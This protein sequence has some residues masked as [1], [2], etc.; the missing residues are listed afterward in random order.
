MH[1]YVYIEMGFARMRKFIKYLDKLVN[2]FVYILFIIVFLYGTYSVYDNLSVYNDA[3]LTKNIIK[4]IPKDDG[5]NFSLTE[6][7]AINEDICGWLRINKTNIDYPI[8]Q[9]KDNLQYLNKNYEK[10]FSS[11]GSI[12]LDYRNS[13]TFEDDYSILYGHNMH[14]NT[15]FSDLTAYKDQEFL[16]EHT[17]GRLYL[18]DKTYKIEIFAYDIIDAYANTI[19]NVNNY[20]NDKN[21]EIASYIKNNA[22]TK[23]ELQIESTDKIIVFSTCVVSQHSSR[24]I[25]AARLQEETQSEIKEKTIQISETETNTRKKVQ[26]PVLDIFI[27]LILIIIIFIFITK[28]RKYRNRRKHKARHA[29]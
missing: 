7:K 6:L 3:K 13:F 14:H 5:S 11:A 24:A 10:E 19:Y 22:I 25:V 26:I 18:E 27:I 9:G 17:E 29:K 2:I 23:K 12:F 20:K 1:F 21:L 8:V 28:K 15:M 16:D 4:C